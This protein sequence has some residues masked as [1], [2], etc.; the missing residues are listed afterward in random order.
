MEPRKTPKIVV[1]FFSLFLFLTGCSVNAEQGSL[2]VENGNLPVSSVQSAPQSSVRNNTQSQISYPIVDTGQVECYHEGVSVDCQ[3]DEEVFFGQD[4][5]Y[6]GSAP[7]YTDNGDGT[8]ID[9]VTGLTW[10]RSRPE[11]EL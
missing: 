8:I 11:D 1:I 5:Q 2:S 10:R 7:S 9:N 4:A 3:T 6:H